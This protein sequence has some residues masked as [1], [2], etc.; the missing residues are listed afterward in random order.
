MGVVPLL[1]GYR[2]C[3]GGLSLSGACWLL[4]CM[5]TSVAEICGCCTVSES[6]ETEP[7]HVQMLK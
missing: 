6:F 1:A 5:S 2:C 7:L 4:F 3:D